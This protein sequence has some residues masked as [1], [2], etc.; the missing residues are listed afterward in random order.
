MLKIFSAKH[1][2]QITN[3]LLLYEIKQITKIF[4]HIVFANNYKQHVKKN[5][6]RKNS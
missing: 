4:T 3:M 2:P 6:I 5:I 1:I